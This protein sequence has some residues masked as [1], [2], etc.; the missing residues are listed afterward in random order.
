MANRPLFNRQRGFAARSAALFLILALTLPN[1]A[2]AGPELSRRT[3]RP[4]GLEESKDKTKNPSMR[5]INGEEILKTYNIPVA[6]HIII[7]DGQRIEAV[8][9][10]HHHV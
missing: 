9:L 10:R 6:A 7:D 3:L 1:P 8:Q 5:I 2:A 4:A